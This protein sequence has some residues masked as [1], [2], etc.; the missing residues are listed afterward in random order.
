M[1]SRD[2]WKTR[3]LPL[4]G[5]VILNE[6]PLEQGMSKPGS[7]ISGFN[8]EPAI[9][10]GYRRITGYQRYSNTAV[11]GAGQILGTFPFYQG[12]V[13]MRGEDVYYGTGAGWTKVNG[14]NVR[15][16]AG[17]YRANR[18]NFVKDSILFCDGV[19]RPATLDRDL[20][21]TPLTN[22]PLA[23]KY[24]VDFKKHMFIAVTGSQQVTF[25]APSDP[26]N[27][28]AL[29]G[30]GTINVGFVPTGFAV[31]RD[32]L[33]V[34]GENQISVIDGT[35][36]TDFTL[37]PVSQNVGCVSGD[38]IQEINGDV[39][40]V[41]ADGVRTIAG[42]MRIGDV[43]LSNL[44]R[45][46]QPKITGL[47]Q[48]FRTNGAVFSA[49][50]I[51]NK[52]QYRVLFSLPN[53]PVDVSGGFLGGIRADG[54]G[55]ASWEWFDL[56][57]L[58]VFCFDSYI[59]ATGDELV[60][61]AHYDPLDGYVYRQE[62]GDNFVNADGSIRP[63]RANIQWPHSPFDDPAQRKTIYRVVGYFDIEGNCDVFA[64]ATLDLAEVGTVQPPS[65]PFVDAVGPAVYDNIAT[66]YDTVYIYDAP[67]QLRAASMLQGS[68]RTISINVSSQEGA[69]YTIRSLYVE[70]SL[71]G[72][73]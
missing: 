50:T 58:R 25:S 72:R 62:R 7:L 57:G 59:L 47:I 28:N 32:R 45:N 53:E 60:V 73:R 24:A 16:G 71:N 34:F 3:P 10:G 41:S 63:V 67:S 37:N 26:T 54:E 43:D 27:Y 19:N 12:C 33:F 15:P 52:A 5:G 21:Y 13:A 8:F 22:A 44:S 35:N 68:G 40:F 39:V 64:G 69:A 4:Y 1:P 18:F 65:V 11:P 14:A 20:V 31:W 6:G 56:I 70:Y 66:V 29:D 9:N 49:A 46:I 51:R 17:K 42:T 2:Q 38:T 23:A 55:G 30:A 36:S 48:S 61:H